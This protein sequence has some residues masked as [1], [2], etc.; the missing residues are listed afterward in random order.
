MNQQTVPTTKKL[1]MYVD[2]L[3]KYTRLL[4]KTEITT[5]SAKAETITNVALNE[6]KP[7]NP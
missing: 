2:C 3:D 7:I 4:T 6:L 5:S 1:M